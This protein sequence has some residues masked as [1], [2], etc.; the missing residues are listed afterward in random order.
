MFYFFFRKLNNN[1]EKSEDFLHDLFI[2]II[3]KPETFDT[4]KSFSPWFYSVAHN[5]VKNEYK[6]IEV[7]KVMDTESDTTQI[8]NRELDAMY[9]RAVI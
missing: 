7:R 3:E 6:K 5:M 9:R 2:K 4:S 8:V 1:Q